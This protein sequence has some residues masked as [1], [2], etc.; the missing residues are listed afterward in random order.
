MSTIE[1]NRVSPEYPP[2]RKLGTVVLGGFV[3][4]LLLAFAFYYFNIELTD[5]T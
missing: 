4:L 2:D 1:N 3:V 5:L